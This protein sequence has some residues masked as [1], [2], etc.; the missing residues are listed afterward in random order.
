MCAFG[1]P[2]WRIAC[3][4][5]DSG[6]AESQLCS[7]YTQPLG[8]DSALGSV[9]SYEVGCLHLS[10]FAAPRWLAH[11][12]IEA[13]LP[14]AEGFVGEDRQKLEFTREALW[15]EDAQP[16]VAV[17]DEAALAA[18][19]WSARLSA[20]EVVRRRERAVR[21][22]EAR[23]AELVRSGAAQRERDRAPAAFA[24]VIRDVNIAL[25]RELALKSGFHDMGCV[26]LFISGAPLLGELPAV[27]NCR[28]Y[29]RSQMDS[30]ELLVASAPGHNANLLRQLRVDPEAE[31][32]LMK[33]REDAA[34]GRMTQPISFPEGVSQEEIC[35]HFRQ[36]VHLLPSFSVTQAKVDGPVR[37]R[38]VVD[39][40]RAGVNG[41][42]CAGESPCVD[43]ADSLISLLRI[44]QRLH[45][46]TPCL[47]KAD[48]D[49]IRTWAP[50][51]LGSWQSLF[52][53]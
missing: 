38:P 31:T 20:E 47:W 25:L 23:G 41:A 49:V 6:T 13:L 9:R 43:N 40:T 3:A 42:T 44:F 24:E 11:Q 26:D 52:G 4:Q 1:L 27:G 8:I 5:V 21:W 19:R 32:L 36:Q 35:A 39:M 17:V 2:F 7:V 53:E 29:A 50:E 30:V 15:A 51:G 48:I 10:P 34:V 22:F 33:A 14:D 37:A 28:P 16:R 46:E 12:E 18:L 45:R